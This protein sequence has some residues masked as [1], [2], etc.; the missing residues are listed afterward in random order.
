MNFP[1]HLVSWINKTTKIIQCFVNQTLKD[2]G[3]PLTSQQLV[4][5]K[6]LSMN[7]GVPQN[8]LAFLTARDKTTLTRLIDTME[9]KKYIARVP[10]ENDKRINLLY[11]TKSGLSLLKNT[12]PEQGEILE[13]MQD[14]ISEE[15]MNTTIKVLQKIQDNI[16]NYNNCP[17]N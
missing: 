13:I 6:V 4:L 9:K 3:I 17:C 7:D 16:G 5:L 2:R 10:D 12:E 8:Q 15:E 11:I 1:D 14:G